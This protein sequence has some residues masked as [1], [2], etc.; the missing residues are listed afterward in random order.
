LA[1]IDLENLDFYLLDESADVEDNFLAYYNSTT[2][3][4]IE[5]LADKKLLL[6]RDEWGL[7]REENSCKRSLKVV[8]RQWSILLLPTEQF[9]DRTFYSEIAI[10]V[11]FLLTASLTIYLAMSIRYT[12]KL[13]KAMQEL[14]ST[15]AQL[16]QAEKM[17]SLGQLVAGVAHEINNPV[18]FIY[19]NINP[20]TEYSQS[21]LKLLE[22]YQEESPN[23]SDKIQDFAA[24][25]DLDFIKEDLPKTI[26]SMKMGAERI[27]K[28]VLSLRN[29]SR[30]DEGQIKLVNLHEVIDSTLRILQGRL[31]ANAEKK[32]I[33]IITN[34]GDLPPV[35]SYTGQLDRALMNLLANAIDALEE[36]R[37]ERDFIPTIEVSTK[38]LAAKNQ[39]IIKIKDNGTGISEEILEDIFNPFFTTKPPGKG[40]GL[41][42]SIAYSI[43]VDRHGGKLKCSSQ[44]GKGTEFIITIPSQQK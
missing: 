36:L 35:E 1:A 24:E 5:N 23:T 28:I 40:S 44:I 6:N 18:N 11:G 3:E 34:Y 17:S 39:I 37:E 25:I 41:G 9:Q 20:I 16:I 10:V 4:I 13:E 19:G 26:E 43:I 7:C 22:L 12:L 33:T 15:Q 14:K 32:A 38:S 8:N 30:F 27:Q 31:T 42:L 21:L 29:F 2:G